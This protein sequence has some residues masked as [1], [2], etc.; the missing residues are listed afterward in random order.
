LR[1]LLLLRVHLLLR[2]L[3]F[4]GSRFGLIGIRHFAQPFGVMLAAHLRR[5]FSAPTGLLNAIRCS[6]HGTATVIV[7]VLEPVS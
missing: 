6:G 2:R 5:Q 7:F 4:E 1:L 3:A